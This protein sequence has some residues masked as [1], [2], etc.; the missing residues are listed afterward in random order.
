MKKIII[1]KRND[2][3]TRPQKKERRFIIKDTSSGMVTNLWDRV[4][5]RCLN[6]DHPAHMRIETNTEVIKSPFFSCE[7][8]EK[9][10]PNRLNIDDYKG[11]VEKLLTIIGKTDNPAVDYT[12]YRF[13]YKGA[14]HKIQV[15]VL[16]YSNEEIKL[17]ILNRT[18]LK[19]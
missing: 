2:E 4:T 9:G 19:L 16:K 6:H 1:T 13:D 12:N 7:M 15:K 17:G 5:I 10:C 18:I 11:V 14:R 8:Y 3:Y